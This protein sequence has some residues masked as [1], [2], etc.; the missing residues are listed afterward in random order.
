MNTIRIHKII[1]RSIVD[2]PG[3]RTVVFFQGCTLAC[4][5]CQNFRLWEKD[6]GYKTR[7]VDLAETLMNLAGKDGNITISG[8]EAFQQ[9]AALAELVYELRKHGAGH[10]L[11]YTGYT[12]EELHQPLHP[13]RFWLEVILERI[14]ILV[15]GRF[16]KAQDDPYIIWRGSRNQRPIDVGRSMAVGE[17]MTLDWDLPEITID[18]SGNLVMP[19]GLA[20]DFSEIGAVK[21]A[22]MCG[23]TRR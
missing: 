5:G 17:V 18:E 16:I 14:N 1:P 6:G 8:G 19:V 22:P 4:P 7:V 21:T 9:P 23:Q 15:D 3:T 11:V 13:A 10:I 20:G 12:W 2:G